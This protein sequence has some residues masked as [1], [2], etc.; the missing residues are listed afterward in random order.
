MSAEAKQAAGPACGVPVPSPATGGAVGLPARSLHLGPT[1]GRLYVE[2][3]KAKPTSPPKTHASLRRRPDAPHLHLQSRREA[4][5]RPTS[6]PCPSGG[7]GVEPVCRFGFPVH[8]GVEPHR[9][10]ALVVA[11]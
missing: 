8:A 5:G 4:V 11:A 7:R 1:V 10:D 9:T 6:S 3:G 2:W